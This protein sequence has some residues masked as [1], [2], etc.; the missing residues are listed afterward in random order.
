VQVRTRS[1]SPERPIKVAAPAPW[2]WPKREDVFRRAA[3]FDPSHVGRRIEPEP[4]RRK[5]SRERGREIAVTRGQSNRGWKALRH[6][7]G[8]ARAGKDGG[9]ITRQHSGRDFGQEQS[10]RVLDALGANDDRYPARR[11]MGRENIQDLPQRLRGDRGE[12]EVRDLDFGRLRDGV[13]IREERHARKT[14]RIDSGCPHLGDVRGIAGPERDFRLLLAGWAG[15]KVGESRAP[16]AGAENGD[17]AFTVW[18]HRIGPSL[19]GLIPSGRA[20]VLA[21]PR[22]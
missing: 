4:G 12:N 5:H 11:Y 7:R 6:V 14:P 18:C 19:L 10:G 16:G 1:P 21:R 8:K 20:I 2:A 9:R 15:G 3:N 17:L 13:D 22:L